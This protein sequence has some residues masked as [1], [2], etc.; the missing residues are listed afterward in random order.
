M[1]LGRGPNPLVAPAPPDRNHRPP[2]P[3]G[4]AA[5]EPPLEV[6]K[7]WPR[8]SAPS[9][10]GVAKHPFGAARRDR[11]SGSFQ[12][13]LTSRLQFRSVLQTSRR[14]ESC[15]SCQILLK[16]S[17]ASLPSSIIDCRVDRGC[18]HCSVHFGRHQP[19]YYIQYHSRP[20]IETLVDP[21][22]RPLAPMPHT[23]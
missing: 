12:P 14:N 3:P 17:R 21:Q 6:E 18:G 22:A 5:A 7:P 8:G 10:H 9:S 1:S 11:A 19:Q 20:A 23:G 13:L 4:P 2:L 16:I 15:A